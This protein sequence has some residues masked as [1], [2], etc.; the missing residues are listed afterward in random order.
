MPAYGN[1]PLENPKSLSI[2]SVDFLESMAVQAPN[3]SATGVLESYSDIYASEIANTLPSR[4][5]KINIFFAEDIE[6]IPGSIRF[7][8]DGLP[9]V[10]CNIKY[11]KKDAPE[12]D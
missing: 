12:S 3:Y 7:E 5:A 10:A 9:A 1:L 4:G 11:L 8:F 2:S 6:L